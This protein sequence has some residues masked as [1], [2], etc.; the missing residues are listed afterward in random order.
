MLQ[1]Y[2]VN[3][4]KMFLLHQLIILSNSYRIIPRF[5]SS[6]TIT[7]MCDSDEYYNPENKLEIF[8]NEFFRSLEENTFIQ[9]QLNDNK[10]INS[11]NILLSNLKNVNARL[12]TLKSGIKVQFTLHYNTN[13]IIKNYDF[14]QANNYM[15]NFFPQSLQDS[16][17]GLTNGKLLNE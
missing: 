16:K 12:V 17:N 11:E 15:Q 6:F 13:D 10:N 2:F 4:L 7:K 9:L 5:I 1:K 14:Q 3:V 8:S